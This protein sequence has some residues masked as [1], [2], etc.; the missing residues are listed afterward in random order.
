MPQ[1]P[2]LYNGEGAR[3]TTAERAQP[4]QSGA[5]RASCQV[6]FTDPAGISDEDTLPLEPHGCLQPLLQGHQE[7]SQ[8]RRGSVGLESCWP[9]PPI[10]GRKNPRSPSTRGQGSFP[11]HLSSQPWVMGCTNGSDVGVRT[12]ACI[13]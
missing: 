11:L 7:N 3:G 8:P 12:E 4:P 2:H 13:T 1:F 5:R 6:L 9:Q 10:L